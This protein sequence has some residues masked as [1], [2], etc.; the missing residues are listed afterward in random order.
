MAEIVGAFLRTEPWDERA[1]S[2]SEARDSSRAGLA[3]ELFKFTVGHLNRVQDRRVLWKVANC[4]LKSTTKFGS[5]PLHLLQV[6][7]RQLTPLLPYLSFEL[8][9][10]AFNAIPICAFSKL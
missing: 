7:I 5:L 6:V 9:P 3:Q 1:N 4:L 2:S 8:V 10:I